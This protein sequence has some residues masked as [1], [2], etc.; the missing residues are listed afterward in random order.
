M[1]QVEVRQAA[2]ASDFAVAKALIEDYAVELGVDLCFQDFGDEL[3]NLQTV[4]GPPDGC[5]LMA[6]VGGE[7][8]GCVAVRKHAEDACEMKRLYVQ[9]RHRGAG[10][11][12]V[13]AEIAIAT[14]GKLG[15]VHMFLDTLPQMSEA[16]ALYASLGFGEI[17][18]YYPN[19]LPGV[20]YLARRL[21]SGGNE[22]NNRA[23]DSVYKPEHQTDARTS[24]K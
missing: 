16:Q 24:G 22:E 18:G 6:C 12:R 20:R 8:A 10:V 13:L 21:G 23:V 19:P 7:V 11:G 9:P 15:Y 2:T 3:A 5:L 1:N 14:A 17:S 4:Y